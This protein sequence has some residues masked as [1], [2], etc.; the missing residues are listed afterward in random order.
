MLNIVP[1]SWMC[2]PSAAELEAIVMNALG[3]L[4]GLD[5]RFLSVPN[6]RNSRFGGGAIQ[7]GASE[8]V[9]VVM[10]AAREKTIACQLDVLGLTL[11]EERE[12]AA[13]SVRIKLVAY[14]SDQ[15]HSSVEKA[16]KI[17][18]CKIHIVP[19]IDGD[20]RLTNASL[21]AAVEKD[22]A[23]GRIP[24]FTCA[25]FGTTN[26]ATI[27]DIAGIANVCEEHYMWLHVDAA[28]AGALLACPEFRPLAAGIERAD[29]FTFN[30]YKGMLTSACCSCMWVADS[31]DINSAMSITREYLP[32][33]D[34]KMEA[35]DNRFWKLQLGQPFSA[36]KLWFVLR[37]HGVSGIRQHIRQKVELAQWLAIQLEEDERF[38]LVVPAVFGLVVF[39]IAPVAVLAITAA[40][41][42]SAEDATRD[43][44]AR[45]NEDGR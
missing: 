39:R 28:Y 9:L 17:L 29:S 15:T 11:E 20:F 33:V 23:K 34:G 41:G 14:C 40:T 12:D 19:T 36:L 3:R 31:R 27:D 5:E 25:S 38:E 32:T 43:L 1:F 44:A 6:Q 42:Y 24:F 4:I 10:A 21:A 7:G 45:I 13:D 35:R 16:A 8:T 22:I 30:P 18:G 2:S 26:T 37:M